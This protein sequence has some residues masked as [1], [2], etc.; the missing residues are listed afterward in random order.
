MEFRRVLF[1]SQRELAGRKIEG[2]SDLFSLGVSLYQLACGKL[3]FAGDSM[4]QLMYRIANEVH[5]DILSVRP[6]LPPC[7]AVI[8]NKSLAKKSE[9]RYAN[10]AEMADAL[11]K[12]AASLG[13]KP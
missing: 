8:V 3:P 9:D 10:G 5:T 1:R 11:R 13:G 12:C 4:A 2:H 6:D 7:L